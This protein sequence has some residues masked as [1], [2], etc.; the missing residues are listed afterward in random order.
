MTQLNAKSSDFINLLGLQRII[1]EDEAAH[2]DKICRATML[3]F[4]IKNREKMHTRTRTFITYL[5]S[6]DT[7]QNVLVFTIIYAVNTAS[8]RVKN[9]NN[10][11]LV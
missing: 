5:H 10:Y 2:K 8:A 9:D 11:G 6:I 3:L 4:Q 7:L 1:F